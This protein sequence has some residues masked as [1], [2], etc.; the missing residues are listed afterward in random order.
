MPGKYAYISFLNATDVTPS[1]IEDGDHLEP[2]Q[3]RF[4][5]SG[6]FSGA[7]WDFVKGGCAIGNAKNPAWFGNDYREKELIYQQTPGFKSVLI[8]FANEESR[9][10]KNA[11][12][13]AKGDVEKKFQSAS[14]VHILSTRFKDPA[15]KHAQ[16][17]KR[18]VERQRGVYLYNPNEDNRK[19]QE[20]DPA[21]ANA[22]WLK[23]WRDMLRATKE[24]RGV[25]IQILCPDRFP[26]SPMQVEEADMAKDK[27]VRVVVLEF[28]S[29]GLSDSEIMAQL[30]M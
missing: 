2:L 4:F 25:C 21:G 17:V 1:I 23:R 27:G 11:A 29:A 20:N 26:M 15:W 28:P 10:R 14:T 9:K 6:A 5:G 18:V 8:N 16:Q 22:K 13:D 24:K 3:R 7:V 12:A 30:G 19:L